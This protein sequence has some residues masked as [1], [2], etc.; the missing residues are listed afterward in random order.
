M[1]IC[2]HNTPLYAHS[3]RIRVYRA[4]KTELGA[5]PHEQLMVQEYF[6]LNNPIGL[7]LGN[8]RRSC[9]VTWQQLHHAVCSICTACSFCKQLFNVHVFS[10]HS[11]WKKL[12]LKGGRPSDQYS[13][14]TYCFAWNHCAI[15]DLHC[16]IFCFTNCQCGHLLNKS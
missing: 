8:L 5:S 4:G 2:W 6:S 16:Y 3:H 11:Q 9:G 7:N 12:K 13:C 14:L 15:D 1:L 10:S